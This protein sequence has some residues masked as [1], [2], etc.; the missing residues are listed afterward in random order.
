MADLIIFI[1]KINMKYI[2]QQEKKTDYG[3][4]KD[5]SRLNDTDLK[6]NNFTLRDYII[7]NLDMSEDIETTIFKEFNQQQNEIEIF[8]LSNLY[9]MLDSF[10]DNS[11]E[12]N[13]PMPKK[14]IGQRNILQSILKDKGVEFDGN[15]KIINN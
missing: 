12:Y 15:H 2:I 5:I 9:T 11:L 4:I 14:M 8:N 7:N 3:S 1:N 6:R 13:F 10:I